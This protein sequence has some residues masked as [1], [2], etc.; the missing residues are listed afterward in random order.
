MCNI[1]CK[2]KKKKQLKWK[3]KI[4]FLTT[5]ANSCF[6]FKHTL[7][8]YYAVKKIEIMSQYTFNPCSRTCFCLTLIHPGKGFGGNET[9]L[10]IKQESTSDW[11]QE[12]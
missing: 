9:E 8:V 5:K 12:N 10:I 4:I 11:L 3:N 6:C 7:K 1:R 2:R